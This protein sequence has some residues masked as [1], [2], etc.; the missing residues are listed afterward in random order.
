MC[1]SLSIRILS[2]LISLR[3]VTSVRCLVK[4]I[5]YGGELSPMDE[6]KFVYGFDSQDTFCDVEASNVL[7][8]GIVLD[9]HSHKITSRQE[10]HDQV[11]IRR[12]LE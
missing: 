11:Q 4:V 2:G 3:R 5:D 10:L 12:V 8:K 6:T 7:G 1:P 9:Q